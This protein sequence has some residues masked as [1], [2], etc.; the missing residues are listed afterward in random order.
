MPKYSRSNIRYIIGK[1]EI[2]ALLN[3]ARNTTEKSWLL[4]LWLT[5]A[6]PA[7]LLEMKKKD[8]KIEDNKTSFRIKTK[9]LGFHR[10]EYIVEK[11]TLVLKIRK[12]HR[13]IKILNAHL[14]KFKNPDKT[15]FKFTRR[16]GLN[17]IYRLSEDV[18]GETLCQYN[19]RHSRM[20]LL[21]EKGATKDEL[22]RFKG[23][24]SDR[25]VASYIHARHVK[26]SIDVDVE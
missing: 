23:S 8:I 11:R 21:A 14:N 17:I 22:K 24:R 3:K 19:F 25:S 4:C 7:E 2:N 6:R 5:A 16:T 18:L 10:K 13:Y 12:E 20:T 15:I 9:K 26:Y 1:D